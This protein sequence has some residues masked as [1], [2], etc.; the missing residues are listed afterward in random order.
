MHSHANLL[1]VPTRFISQDEL[2]REEPQVRARTAI[3]E[4]SSTGILD[5]HGLMM[6]LQ[7]QFEDHGGD[8]ALNTTVTSISARQ[9]GG[10]DVCFRTAEGEEM[11][12]D[13][14]VVV[15]SAG[16][17]ACQVSNMLLPRER[18]VTPYYA[19]GNYFSYSSGYPRPKRLI[20][21]CPGKNFAGSFPLLK[22]KSVL[23]TDIE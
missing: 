15:N 3:L 7:S 6:Y 1:N 16:L 8:V 12:I 10:Y 21:P 13:A 17:Y 19:K 20:Y 4:S 11:M 9:T 22:R 14:G 2:A 18:Q 5:S 23:C